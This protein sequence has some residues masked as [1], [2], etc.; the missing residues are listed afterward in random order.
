M[1]SKIDAPPTS[2]RRPWAGAPTATVELQDG[3]ER[4]ATVL[5]TDDATDRAVL[6]IDASGLDLEPLALGGSAGLTV[7]DEAAAIDVVA[8][9]ASTLAKGGTARHAHIGVATGDDTSANG[10]V[11]GTVTQGGPAE[12]A[13]LE[14]GDVTAKG[15]T[16]PAQSAG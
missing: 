10:A 13:G 1:P 15:G 3:T 12:T 5:G 6:K 11:V 4:T 8:K 9:E 16:Q 14:P 2:E 7:G